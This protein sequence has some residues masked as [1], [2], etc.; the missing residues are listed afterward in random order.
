MLLDACKQIKRLQTVDSESL[1]EVVVRIQCRHRNLEMLRGQPQHF[2]SRILE[3]RH[4]VYLATDS[5]RFERRPLGQ[6]GKRVSALN[7]LPQP[8]FHRRPRKQ[9]AEN[10]HFLFQ[11]RVRNRL[12]EFLGRNC[13]SAIKLRHLRR[14]HTR[15]SQRVTFPRH[16]AHEPNR[17]RLRRVDTAPRQKQIPHHTIPNVALEPR[18][19][20]KARYQSQPKLGKTE[21]RHFI[22]NDQIAKQRQLKSA[23][24]SNPVHR[25]NRRKRCCINRNSYAVNPFDKLAHASDTLG[26]RQ[27]LRSVIQFAQICPGAESLST[28]TGNNQCVAVL[29]QLLKRAY[30][31]LK[32]GEG[33]GTDLIT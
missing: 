17:L 33:R 15:H 13:R 28:R 1:E 12:D 9:L 19:S 6:I 18:N 24:E 27:R 2:V 5:S 16:L 21:A 14:S 30:K 20:A 3:C 7:E 26:R 25:R 29:L 11:L 10:I 22:R 23:A 32:V 4:S 31:L 8:R